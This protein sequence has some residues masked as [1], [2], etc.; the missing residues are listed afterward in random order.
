M[1]E[2]SPFLSA[3][4]DWLGGIDDEGRC[5]RCGFDW[6]VDWNTSWREALDIIG[7]SPTRVASLLDGR[8][9]MAV[10]ADGGWNAAAYVWHLSDLARSW[11]ERWVQLQ[12][13]PGSLLIGWDPDELAWVRNYTALPTAPA[14]WALATS[15]TAFVALTE[16][17]PAETT[18]LHGDWG[19]GTVG[20][21][22]GWLAHEHLHHLRDIDERA[23][24]PPSE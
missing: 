17:L 21:V 3:A 14:L 12:S 13:D 18:F 15:T 23:A 20:E 19:P 9:A 24:N 22:I 10:A 7:A 6:S 2:R 16:L 11:S 1:V 4:L 8:D 5:R